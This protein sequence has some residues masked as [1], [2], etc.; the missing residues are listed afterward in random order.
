MGSLLKDQ[1]LEELKDKILDH[2]KR[3][4]GSSHSFIIS[5]RHRKIL[6]DARSELQAGHNLIQ[7]RAAE[8][9]VLAS[10]H[11]RCALENLG[12]ITGRTYTEELLDSIFSRFC[13]GK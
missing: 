8:L 4:S 10:N 2:I 13:V 11:L 1:G 9:I 5:E 7:K 6:V 3:Q 12:T